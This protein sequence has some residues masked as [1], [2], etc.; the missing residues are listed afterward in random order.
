MLYICNYKKEHPS[1]I[2]EKTSGWPT[3][4]LQWPGANQGDGGV[5]AFSLLIQ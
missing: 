1:L 2:A 3:I 5:G 4:D